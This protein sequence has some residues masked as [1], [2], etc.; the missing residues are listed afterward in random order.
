MKKKK[1]NKY[2]CFVDL[3]S[4][5]DNMSFPILIQKYKKKIIIK[6]K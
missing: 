3:L 1:K 4:G 2:K 6:F 5:F